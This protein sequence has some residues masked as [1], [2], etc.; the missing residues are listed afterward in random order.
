MNT[1]PYSTESVQ[2][3]ITAEFIPLK[4]QCFWKER[5]DLMKEFDI[6]WTPTFLFHDTAGKVHRKLV[7]Y[8]PTDD[9]LAQMVFA[10]GMIYFEKARN[11]EAAKW[12]QRVVSEHPSAGVA[13]EAVFFLGVA[14]YKKTHEAIY[15]RRTHDTLM[16][17]YPAS[18]WTRR[19]NP[20][21]AIPA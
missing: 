21:A 2:A 9:F 14:G 13:P 12:F 4:S 7:G 10:K 17:L 1:G 18:Q 16:K 6:A 15:L 19:A 20:Y 3:F 11:E 8:L 5:T